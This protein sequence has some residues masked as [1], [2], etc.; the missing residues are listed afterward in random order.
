MVEQVAMRRG[1]WRLVIVAATECTDAGEAVTDV[2]GVRD[3]A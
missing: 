1:L 2:G 3:L